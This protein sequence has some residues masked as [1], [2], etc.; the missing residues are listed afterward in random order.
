MKPALYTY[1]ERGYGSTLF[2]SDSDPRINNTNVED[3]TVL[4]DIDFT[5]FKLVPLYPTEEMVQA[6]LDE[7]RAGNP[8]EDSIYSYLEAAPDTEDL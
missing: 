3:V 4:W 5:K 8:I 6:A 2:T 7:Q 1:Y